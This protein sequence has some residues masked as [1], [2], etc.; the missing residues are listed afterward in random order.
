[1]WRHSYLADP[2]F[3]QQ[4]QSAPIPTAAPSN[5]EEAN[6]LQ[7]VS[8]LRQLVLLLGLALALT[9]PLLVLLVG[10]VR[11]LLYRL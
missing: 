11:G 1:M 8:S 5:N 6:L 7:A 9:L 3:Q 10:L 4:Q 2:H